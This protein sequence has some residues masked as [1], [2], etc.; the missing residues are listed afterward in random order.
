MTGLVDMKLDETGRVERADTHVG[1]GTPRRC[2]NDECAPRTTLRA[3]SAER[4]ELR[5]LVEELSDDRVRAVLAEWHGRRHWL[6]ERRPARAGMQRRR[7]LGPDTGC[8]RPLSTDQ[9]DVN[10]AH[11]RKR[12]PGERA[13]AKLKT[14]KVLRKIRSSPSQATTRVKAVQTLNPLRLIKR[15][16]LSMS[17]PVRRRA[18]ALLRIARRS[19]GSV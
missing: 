13:N 11:A 10:A 6:P 4:D 18:Y 17:N 12:G 14:W 1:R 2:G 3:V 16:G 19:G 8:C 7:R 5:R 15:E 9:K